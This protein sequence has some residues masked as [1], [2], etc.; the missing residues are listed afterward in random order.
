MTDTPHFQ[1]FIDGAWCEG[2]GQQVMAT[3]NPATGQDWAT[4]AC[5]DAVDVDQAVMAA[6]RALNDPAWRDMTQTVRGRLLYHLADLI[7]DNAQKLGALEPTDSGKLLAETAA[8]AMANLVTAVL[9]VAYLVS[10]RRSGAVQ[11][12]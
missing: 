9:R 1:L 4:F 6:R 3:Q 7:E 8:L 2:H 11:G 10:A 12:C 5:A